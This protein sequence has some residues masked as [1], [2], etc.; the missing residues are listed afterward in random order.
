MHITSYSQTASDFFKKGQDKHE[1]LDI[2][3][4][5]E[6]FTRAI[7][8][9]TNYLEAY[10][11]RAHLLRN[12]DSGREGAIRDYTRVIA[13][14]STNAMAF[15]ERGCVLYESIS[16]NDLSTRDFKEAA[17]RSSPEQCYWICQHIEFNYLAD[18]LYDEGISLLE[19]LRQLCP[20]NDSTIQSFIRSLESGRALKRD[21][22]ERVKTD[23]IESSYMGMYYVRATIGNWKAASFREYDGSDVISEPMFQYRFSFETRYLA[24]GI[25]FVHHA[26]SIVPFSDGTIPENIGKWQMLGIGCNLITRFWVFSRDF[27]VVIFVD[28]V[29]TWSRRVDKTKAITPESFNSHDMLKQWDGMVAVGLEYFFNKNFA[30]TAGTGVP[31]WL[32][33]GMTYRIE[34]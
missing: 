1:A 22:M 6:A 31:V 10:M 3:G 15:F 33:G 19:E 18:S 23:S 20:T 12:L 26:Y 29:Y 27:S 9:D 17:R 16:R 2:K 14:D 8:L 28:E 11:Q 7:E 34:F 13:L 30:L 32:W 25:T 24:F 21:Q 4:A 5:I